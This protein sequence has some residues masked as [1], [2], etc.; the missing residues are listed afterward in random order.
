[1]PKK[2]PLKCCCGHP[3]PYTCASVHNPDISID[4]FGD[5]ADA[6]EQCECSC[7]YADQDGMD[8]EEREYDPPRFDDDVI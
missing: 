3:D 2:I 1:M 4:Y 7:H 8:D 5:E 6:D